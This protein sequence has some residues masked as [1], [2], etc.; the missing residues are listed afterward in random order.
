M[1]SLS[2][3]YEALRGRVSTLE[4]QRQF[5]EGKKEAHDKAKAALLQEAKEL[6]VEGTDLQMIKG[7]LEKRVRDDLASLEV[8]VQAAEEQF[9]KLRKTDVNVET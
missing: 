9:T 8:S 6:K 2:E 7:V 4:A 1:A 5:W 3:G